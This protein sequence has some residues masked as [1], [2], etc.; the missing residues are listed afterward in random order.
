MP[1]QSDEE[2]KVPK[3]ADDQ[4]YALADNEKLK[5]GLQDSMDASDPRL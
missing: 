4:D 3:P 1:D 5:E 2:R